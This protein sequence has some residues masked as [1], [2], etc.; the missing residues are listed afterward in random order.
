M[1]GRRGRVVRRPDG[2]VRY[3]SRAEQG[4]TIDH[5]NL[6]EKDRFMGGEKVKMNICHR[7]NCLC[8]ALTL[9]YHKYKPLS[10]P[11]GGHYLRGC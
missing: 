10:F 6:K 2:S 1:T 11:V 7:Q 5:I 9:Q 8:H 4:L 3:E